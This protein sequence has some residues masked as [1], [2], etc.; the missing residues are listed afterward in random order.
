MLLATILLSC[1]DKANWRTIK[2]TASFYCV[3][4]FIK[5]FDN[6]LCKPCIHVF[7]PW[8]DIS[9]TPRR[10][11]DPSCPHAWEPKVRTFRF[12]LFS[13]WLNLDTHSLFYG[14]NPGIEHS[15]S[16]FLLAP[17]SHALWLLW[18]GAG[19]RAAAHHDG[20]D[21]YRHQQD[22]GQ[23]RKAD[24]QDVEGPPL[25]GQ[26]ECNIDVFSLL[27]LHNV[28]SVPCYF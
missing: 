25:Q 13:Q 16:T 27:L 7:K 21:D 8:R 18:A 20:E 17:D 9:I 12:Q 26:S 24:E 14:T 11:F 4:S 19:R 28:T 5:S 2:F 6:L 15:V 10:W 22:L 3:K 23:H 1:P